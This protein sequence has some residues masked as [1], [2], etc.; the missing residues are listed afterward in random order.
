MSQD[1]SWLG[2][3]APTPLDHPEQVLW[4]L[5]KGDGHVAK[6]IAK[7]MP[8]CNDLRVEVDGSLIRSVCSASGKSASTWKPRVALR[9]R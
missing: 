2:R 8:Y 6:A 9:L 3:S 4:T 7:Y 1:F 5:A